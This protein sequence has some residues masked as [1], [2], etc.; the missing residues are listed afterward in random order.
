MM[1]V[2]TML[3]VIV[4][5]TLIFLEVTTSQIHFPAPDDRECTLMAEIRTIGLRRDKSQFEKVRAALWERHPG[6]VITAIMALGRLGVK[7][8]EEELRALQTLIP[9]YSSFIQLA[10]ARLKTENAFPDISNNWQFCQKIA[11]FLKILNKSENQINQI[12]SKYAENLQKLPTSLIGTPIEVQALRQIAEMATEAY[13][14][15]IHNAFASL[16]LDFSLDPVAQLKVKL[17]QMSSKERI[18]WLVDLLSRKKVL[19]WQE[20]Y[21]M[22]ALAD[23]GKEAVEAIIAKLKEMAIKR[24]DYPAHAGFAA[25]FRTLVSIGDHKAIPVIET[26]LNDNNEWVRYYAQ[27]AL[28]DLK[29]G[30]R[31]VRALDY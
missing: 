4:I 16:K 9:E 21:E 30:R 24:Q 12:A 23:E 3:S 26:F 17:G 14:K 27:Q 11:Y 7:E 6:I 5:M 28:G 19:R 18:R 8:A 22:Q 20:N 25:L 31:V 10:L 15:G 29:Q 13:A 1:R 2:A